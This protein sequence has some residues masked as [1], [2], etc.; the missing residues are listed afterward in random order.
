MT[1]KGY[2]IS[3]EGGEGA[4][5]TTQVE[6]LAERLK[7]EGLEVV[8]CREPGGTEI[9]EQIRQVVLSIKNKGMDTNAELLLFMAARAQL[10]G[11][12][13]RPALD[14]G[15]IVLADRGRDSSVVYQGMV[16]GLGEEWVEKLND[17][18][19]KNVKPDLTFLLDVP[20]E[21]GHK[22]YLDVNRFENEEREFHEKVRQ[23]YKQLAKKEPGRWVVIDASRTAAEVEEEVWE[24]CSKYV[25]G[26]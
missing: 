13:V 11:E 25:V 14:R 8:V 16:R 9:G 21:I 2:F 6:L 3:F 10:F 15:A 20:V 19:M 23:G 7:K 1:D 12:V 22:R 18:A 5:K 4:G 26:D 24:R 17:F